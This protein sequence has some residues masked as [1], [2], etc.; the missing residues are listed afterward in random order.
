MNGVYAY[1]DKE[2]NNKIVYIG[3]DSYID[4]NK[5]YNDHISSSK[6]D[7]QPFNRVLQ[8]NPNRYKYKVLKK[9][10]FSN[11]LLKALEVIYIKR[12][13]PKFNFTVGGDG[14]LGYKHSKEIKKKI[15]EANKG[16]KFS[17]KHKKNLSLSHKGKNNPFFGKHHSEKTKK[18]ISK[19]N[20]GKHHSVATKEKMSKTKNTSGYYRVYKNKTKNCKQGFRWVYRWTDKNGKRKSL[21][22]NN[23][24]KLEKKVKEKGLIW[25]KITN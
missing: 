5:R 18:K 20:T 11:N 13:Q 16:R 17:K 8:N 7:D 9:G 23:I 21:S 19:A 6:Y 4:K 24:K 10:N 3:I 22:N 12:Y 25:E 14:V 2:K 15:S 1:I